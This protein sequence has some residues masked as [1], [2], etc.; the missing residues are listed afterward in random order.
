M[1]S[2]WGRKTKSRRNGTV[3]ALIS[4]RVDPE[5]LASMLGGNFTEAEKGLRARVT[6]SRGFTSREG[7]SSRITFDHVILQW[8]HGPAVHKGT[9]IFLDFLLHITEKED[10]GTDQSNVDGW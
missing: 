3:T 1:L 2:V 4:L 10:A 7:N 8:F 9:E 5:P 6:L